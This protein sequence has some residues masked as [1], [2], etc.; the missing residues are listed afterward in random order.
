MNMK[1]K[2][3]LTRRGTLQPEAH[4]WVSDLIVDCRF[5]YVFKGS[6]TGGSQFKRKMFNVSSLITFKYVKCSQTC[7]LVNKIF[8]KP[9]ADSIISVLYCFIIST[10]VGRLVTNKCSRMSLS[11]LAGFLYN[12]SEGACWADAECSHEVTVVGIEMWIIKIKLLV[13]FPFLT[14]LQESVSRNVW[15]VLCWVWAKQTIEWWV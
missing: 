5:W 14:E 12:V 8:S 10:W 3:G 9:P 15:R 7:F 13:L 1:H 4:L 2:T 11:I 6:V